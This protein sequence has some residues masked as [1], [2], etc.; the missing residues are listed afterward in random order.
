MKSLDLKQEQLQQAP[1]GHQVLKPRRI[2]DI[3]GVTGTLPL[4]PG[5]IILT[6]HEKKKLFRFGWKEGDPL[7][8]NIANLVSK[9]QREVADDLRTTKPFKN[10][11]IFKA[12]EPVDID[13]LSDAKRSELEGHLKQFKEM[14]PQIEMAMK[15]QQ[16]MAGLSPEIQKAIKDAG[17]IEVV[18]SRE[19]DDPVNELQRKIDEAE[20][21]K[22]PRDQEGTGL[23]EE[24]K[25]EASPTSHTKCPRCNWTLTNKPSEPSHD[26]KLKYV[27]AIL[28]DQPF[29]KEYSL[30]GGKLIISLR[31]LTTSRSDL[32]YNQTAHEIRVGLLSDNTYR[33]IMLYR[34]ILS[35]NRVSTGGQ[36][37]VDIGE[38]VDSFLEEFIDADKQHEVMPIILKRLQTIEPLQNESI[39]RACYSS[40][41][42]F[43]ALLDDL[44]A[45][46]DNP[47]FWNAIEV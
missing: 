23:D 26:D 3:R 28:G 12:P 2:K 29:E 1:A 41:E 15:N 27:A 18:D 30:Y 11:P 36:E 8:G 37:P 6:E 10:R 24:V 4:Q 14:A 39:W 42:K 16:D 25:P 35:L 32:V 46:A 38:I 17:G 33:Q 5:E 21:R 43:N 34:M 44:D 22:E 31:Q 13:T 9:A 20:G 7:P 45:R 40:F 47:D 19:Q